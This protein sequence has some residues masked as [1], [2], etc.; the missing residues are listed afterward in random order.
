MSDK[1]FYVAGLMFTDD[2]IDVAVIRK[3]HPEW[4]EG[5]FNAIGGKIEENETSNNAMIREFEEETGLRHETWYKFL[6]VYNDYFDVSFF[7]TSVDRETIYKTDSKT[8]EAVFILPI[9]QVL[10]M[11]DADLAIP[12]LRWIVP[13]AVDWYENTN[14]DFEMRF[15]EL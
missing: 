14:R 10:T 12:N 8:D 6:N 2:M 4:Q 9:D 15:K 5:K 11:T 7:V 1:K 3:N 13:L